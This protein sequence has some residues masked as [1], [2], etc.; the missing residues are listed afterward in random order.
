M[1]LLG[2]QL[3]AAGVTFVEAKGRHRDGKLEVLFVLVE[4]EADV[5]KVRAWAARRGETVVLDPDVVRVATA[6]ELAEHRKWQE[7][8]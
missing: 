5:D 7:C 3:Q 6:E 8:W 4:T 1:M 2:T